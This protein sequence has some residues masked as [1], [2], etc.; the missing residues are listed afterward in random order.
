M[1]WKFF[2]ERECPKIH[3]W[4]FWYPLKL[5]PPPLL[6][7]VSFFVKRNLQ[8]SSHNSP[9]NIRDEL[10][11]C[12]STIS[13]FAASNSLS[14]SGNLTFSSEDMV[15]ELGRRKEELWNDSMLFKHSLSSF[16]KYWWLA[17]LAPFAMHDFL[18]EISERGVDNKLNL[19]LVVFN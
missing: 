9:I 2:F 12:G 19:T 4:C 16:L 18:D 7:T 11:N 17:A 8:Y 14:K 13:V 3:R 6:H 5:Y 15:E 10:L 1:E